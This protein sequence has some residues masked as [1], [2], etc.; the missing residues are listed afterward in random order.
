MQGNQ[1]TSDY[2][3]GR[4]TSRNRLARAAIPGRSATPKSDLQLRGRK[5]DWQARSA[6][7]QSLHVCPHENPHRPAGKEIRARR[8]CPFRAWPG[9]PWSRCRTSAAAAKDLLQLSNTTEAPEARQE[10]SVV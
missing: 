7:Q 5:E 9:R 2:W 1:V 6:S 3:V 4:P 8:D 10:P